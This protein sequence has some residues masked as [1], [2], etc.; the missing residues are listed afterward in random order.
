[1]LRE[2]ANRK[3]TRHGLQGADAARMMAVAA[4]A[5]KCTVPF[6]SGTAPAEVAVARSSVPS[7]ANTAPAAVVVTRSS[8]SGVA[9]IAPVAV[10]VA[11]S[12]S[13]C[14]RRHCYCCRALRSA[15]V[16]ALYASRALS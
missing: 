15:L 12:R 8:N 16:S 11:P 3:K 14:S 2:K 4:A 1:M 13:G 7:A 6:A 9:G 5:R 10:A